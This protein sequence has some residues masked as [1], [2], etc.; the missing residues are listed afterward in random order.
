M[1]C[2]LKFSCDVCDVEL[3]VIQLGRERS[4]PLL[5]RVLYPDLGSTLTGMQVSPMYWALLGKR[6]RP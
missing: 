5:Y 1:F 6:P 2:S 3:N 4:G